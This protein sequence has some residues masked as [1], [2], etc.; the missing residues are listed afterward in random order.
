MTCPRCDDDGCCWLC[1][2]G[3]DGYPGH[4]R[5]PAD[6]DDLDFHKNRD[7]EIEDRA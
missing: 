6:Q 5:H 7:Y 2:W 1:Y 3:E 4:T